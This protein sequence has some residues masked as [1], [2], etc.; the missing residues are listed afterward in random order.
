MKRLIYLILM[1]IMMLSPA[2][3]DNIPGTSIV[4]LNSTDKICTA[5]QTNQTLKVGVD[6]YYNGPR[7]IPS[8]T[9]SCID[10]TNKL[11]GRT[12]KANI[13]KIDDK[14]VKESGK[15][16]DYSYIYFRNDKLANGESI[17]MTIDVSDKNVKGNSYKDLRLLMKAQSSTSLQTYNSLVYYVIT[18]KKTYGPFPFEF[19]EFNNV[20]TETNTSGS[21]SSLV[22][23]DIVSSNLIGKDKLGNKMGSSEIIQKIKIVPYENKPTKSGIFRLF[24]LSLNGYSS[25]YVGEKTVVVDNAEDLIRHNV[26]NNMIRSITIKWDA[27]PNNNRKMFAYYTDGRALVK[28][29]GTSKNV[30]YGLPYSTATAIKSTVYSF[31]SQ[32]EQG[33]SKNNAL[34]SYKITDKY[35]SNITTSNGNKYNKGDA[36]NGDL[37]VFIESDSPSTCKTTALEAYQKRIKNKSTIYFTDQDLNNND[38]V[39]NSG[40]YLFGHSCS[41][42]AM[43]AI[44]PEV[45]NR[46]YISSYTYFN[47]SSVEILGGITTSFKEVSDI[48]RKEGK[49]TSE[50]SI[51]QDTYNSN[52]TRIL[53]E[54]YKDPQ[55]FYNAY[56]LTLPGDMIVH[57]GH[58]R[59]VSG[60]P[61]IVCK[62]GKHKF[63]GNN[64]TDLYSNNYC[65]KYGGI[66]PDNSFVITTEGGTAYVARSGENH[67][68][69][70]D[71]SWKITLDKKYTDLT[72]VDQIYNGKILSTA[73]PNLKY[74]FTELYTDKRMYL[75]FRYKALI[76]MSTTNEIAVPNTRIVL[77]KEYLNQ[78]QELYNYMAENKKLKGTILSNYMIDGIR[79]DIN[80]TKYYIYPNQV[81]KFSLYSGISNDEI[82]NAIKNVNYSNNN[83]I[84]ISV[85]SGPNVQAV[86]NAAN[87]DSEGYVTVFDSTGLIIP[88]PTTGIKLNKS[89]LTINV[90]SSS[91]VKTTISPSNAT[92]TSVTWSTSDSKI[93]TVSNGK[94]TGVNPGTATITVKTKDTGKTA[95]LIVVVTKAV[96]SVSLNKTTTTININ[97]TEK[98]VATVSPSDATDKTVTWTSS[99]TKIVTVNNGTITGIK[100]G[101][102]TVSA[103]TKDGNKVAKITVHVVKPT[104]G[105]K[106]IT[107]NKT[108]TSIKA[109]SSE[110]IEA[111]ISPSDATN[112][113]ITWTSSDENIAIVNDG[114]VIGKKEG[115][116]TITA[117]TND[118]DKVASVDVTISEVAIENIK[119]NLNEVELLVGDNY[120]ASVKITPDNASNKTINWIS[121]DDSIASVNN[122]MITAIK[123]GTA[124]ITAIAADGTHKDTMVVT[125]L[126]EDAIVEEPIDTFENLPEEDEKEVVQEEI[127]AKQ[128]TE[129]KETVEEQE[130]TEDNNTDEYSD[131]LNNEEQEEKIIDEHKEETQKNSS[132]ILPYVIVAIV[133]SLGIALGIYLFLQ[134]KKLKK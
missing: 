17:F 93:A 28:V 114:L 55:T 89:S 92:N 74:T 81:Y 53:K 117:V 108:K 107:L 91:T 128:E 66:D 122:G 86:R 73:R 127:D 113:S 94:I 6:N 41:T 109:G 131:E 19:I 10:S 20:Y 49:L 72:N 100:E 29:D 5:L 119:L 79:F 38:F 75:P 40:G 112:K 2:G 47:S 42:S 37:H 80:G 118:G 104:V 52:Y 43:A 12:T 64:G 44:A 18:N 115:T 88:V 67:V 14:V 83:K 129:N 110:K 24:S 102:A 39:N 98:I 33:V 123:S 65:A 68:L 54:K 36:I 90:G 31:A 133:V 126:G 77:D 50:T 35:L 48:L 111:T 34:Y 71:S 85:K 96:T 106:S 105:V 32:T 27:S 69:T 99:D 78:N 61:T 116:V 124:T 25:A 7:E 3:V 15:Y 60:Y 51:S 13:I 82:L 59:V 56:A 4:N 130:K 76:K 45:T 87:A 26:V 95:S 58:V 9:S 120:E 23:Y 11:F 22:V 57:T 101:T 97:K 8:S 125:V 63:G 16:G 30:Y 132:N 103:T 62:D 70:K 134:K 121:S 1:S 46:E 84:K 21:D